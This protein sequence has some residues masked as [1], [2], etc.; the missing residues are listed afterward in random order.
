M[1]VMSKIA[2]DLLPFYM[3]GREAKLTRIRKLCADPEDLCQAVLD[4]N[5]G[6]RDA[7]A[8]AAQRAADLLR[9]DARY[10][11]QWSKDSAD[12][13][14][15][16][17]TDDLSRAFDAYIVGLR[18]ELAYVLEPDVLECISD[19]LEEVDDDE[20]GDDEVEDEEEDE[21]D[22]PPTPR[23]LHG[24]DPLTLVREAVRSMPASGRFGHEK[25]FISEIWKRVGKRVAG[26]LPTLDEFKLWLV[27]Q[28]RTRAL[29]LAR[30]DLVG[31][32][33]P[34]KV[35]E[36]E[37]TDLGATFHFVIDPEAKF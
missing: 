30:A 13:V 29:T 16:L 12:E 3:A 22:D 17:S 31:A 35:Q 32:M 9:S 33:D 15:E 19:E 25:V 10:R 2:S 34:K 37:I 5:E 27:T 26:T 21:D 11:K 4:G 23:L 28:N 36:S 18:D 24:A 7:C 1:A 20:D 8:G 6:V 14:A